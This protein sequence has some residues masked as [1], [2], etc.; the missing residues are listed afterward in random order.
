MKRTKKK[1]FFTYCFLGKRDGVTTILGHTRTPDLFR[2]ELH[3]KGWSD[4]ELHVEE[5][6]DTI[7]SIDLKKL[8]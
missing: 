2:V 4:K 5:L 6:D 3:R 1:N 7:K 8:K